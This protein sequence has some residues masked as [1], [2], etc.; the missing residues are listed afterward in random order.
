MKD[1]VILGLGTE[2]KDNAELEVS[3]GEVVTKLAPGDVTE[4]LSGLYF[5]DDPTVHQHNKSVLS[6]LHS[7]EHD[8]DR[9]LALY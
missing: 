9:N 3:C 2:V 4:A 7:I 1:A 6:N 5:K 8:R